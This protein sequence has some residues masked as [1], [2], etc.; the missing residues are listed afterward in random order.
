MQLSGHF[1]LSEFVESAT[2]SRLGINND[3][4]IALTQAAKNTA[5]MMERVRE[6]LSSGSAIQV[7]IS[8]TSAYRC[9]ALNRALKSSDSSDHIKMLAVDFKAPQFG[10]PLDVCRTL[11]PLMD[12]LG[13]GQLIYEFS[14]VHISSRAPDK[15]INRILT[16]QGNGYAAGILE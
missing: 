9:Q 13:I 6:A 8:I 2:A 4:P 1:S 11:V 15:Q 14:W 3:L 5:Q 16:V 7:P 10:S 12:Y